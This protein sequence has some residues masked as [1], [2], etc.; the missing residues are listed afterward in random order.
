MYKLLQIHTASTDNNGE[1][2]VQNNLLLFK[3]IDRGGLSPPTSRETQPM[4]MT[5]TCFSGLQLQ[6]V[7]CANTS[8][9]H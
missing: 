5:D 4:S 3:T 1:P 9:S 7:P 2:F 6:Y 8:V